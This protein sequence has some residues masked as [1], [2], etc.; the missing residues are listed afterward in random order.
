MED[1]EPAI[2]FTEEQITR[3]QRSC[4]SML[5]ELD[6]GGVDAPEF[7]SEVQQ[8]LAA[9]ASSQS[10]YSATLEKA[11][12]HSQELDN[13]RRAANEVKHEEEDLQLGIKMMQDETVKLN[14]ETQKVR[15]NLNTTQKSVTDKKAKIAG[16]EA[17]KSFGA[18]WTGDQTK[19][20]EALE[21]QRASA[22]A[23]LDAK[24]ITLSNLRMEVQLL[25]GHVER[26]QGDKSAA[27]KKASELKESIANHRASAAALQR[28]KDNKDKQLSELQQSVVALN[29]ELR[30]KTGA[31]EAGSKDVMGAQD[32]LKR[33][34]QTL[35]RYVKEYDRLKAKAQR[36]TEDIDESMRQNQGVAAEIQELQGKID[37]F[38][39]EESRLRRD[40]EK[41]TKLHSLCLEKIKETENKISDAENKVSQVKSQMDALEKEVQSERRLLESKQQGAADMVREKEVLGKGLSKQGDK[42]KGAQAAA[43]FQSGVKKMLE[44]EISGYI[45]TLKRLRDEIDELQVARLKLVAELDVAAQSYFT[46][47]EGVKLQELQIA[48]L[49]RKIEEGN[50]KLRQQQSLYESVKADRN[51]YSKQLVSAHAELNEMKRDFKNLTRRIEALKEEITGKDETLVKLHFQHH[52]VEKEKE[53]L[54]AEV[55]R[56]AKQV[57]ACDHIAGNQES[58]IKKLSAIVAE[59]EAEY[60]RQQKELDAVKA[61]RTL[62]LQQLQKRD[63]E[64]TQLYG[65]LQVQ[66]SMLANGAAAFARKAAERDELAAKVAARKGDLLLATTQ[67][68]DTSAL[69]NECNKLENDLR[70][71]KAR[72]R[73]LTEELE[74]PINI[75]RWRALED[76]DPEKWTLIQKMHSMQRR[77]LEVRE[78]IK[79][80]D[81]AIKVAEVEYNKLKGHLSKAPG[82]EMAEAIAQCQSNLKE[83]ARQMKALEL[84]LENARQQCDDYKREMARIDEG[85][86]RM[87]QE[88]IRRMKAARRRATSM[89]PGLAAAAAGAMRSLDDSMLSAGGAGWL[90]VTAAGFEVGA[91]V[92]TGRR[93]VATAATGAAGTQK[94]SAAAVNAAADRLLAQYEHVLPSS[95]DNSTSASEEKKSDDSQT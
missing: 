25:A 40:A 74:R 19:E 36:L 9:L 22:Q 78:E 41:A 6:A 13:V 35:D 73:A 94:L 52:R 95:L 2:L 30:L 10:T 44:S 29:E 14:A 54:K 77:V 69:E 12:Q 24:R 75:H 46:A 59:A 15:A 67:L 39:S 92:A 82:P 38:R 80:R 71:E 50:T 58:E 66:K 76:R 42:A 87:T 70:N 86:E 93:C 4:E 62:L 91:A 8:M 89:G 68:S 17:Q 34:R 21:S 11:K 33:D 48:A 53:S 26:A 51:Q 37:S 64:L 88:Y 43:S 31:A 45:S 61:E 47:A 55:Q 3:S 18:G 32:S 90:D 27:D 49:Q 7:R 84:D 57:Q 81:D 79:A 5:K 72:I 83:K 63:A 20:R 23:E 1:G 60:T 65:K 16:L 28:S 85:M 56:V